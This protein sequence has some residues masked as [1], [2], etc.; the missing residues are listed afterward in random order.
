MATCLGID[1]FFK[2][3]QIN[4]CTHDS[5]TA[6]LRIHN[7][8]EKKERM[9][10][11]TPHQYLLKKTSLFTFLFLF[12]LRFFFFIDVAQQAAET[13]GESQTKQKQCNGTVVVSR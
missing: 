8:I 10:Y 4:K 12:Y 7:L 13:W 9:F 3:I 2:K 1:T 5:T 6:T 11:N